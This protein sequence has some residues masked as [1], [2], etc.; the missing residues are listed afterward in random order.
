MS[1]PAYQIFEE[2]IAG[3]KKAGRY[4]DLKTITGPVGTTV[5]MDGMEMILLCSNNYLGLATHPR[6]K[7]AE[8]SALK[9]YGTGACASRLISGLPR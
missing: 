5:F 6:I 7:E 1:L 8:A 4:R 9:K 2:E 3:L